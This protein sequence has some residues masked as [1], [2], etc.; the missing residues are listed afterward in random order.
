M[1][2]KRQSPDPVGP[3]PTATDLYGVDGVPEEHRVA[4]GRYTVIPKAK[5]L[6]NGNWIVEIVLEEPRAD[7]RRQYDFFGPMNEYSSAEEARRAGVEHA[8]GR[9]DEQ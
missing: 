4:H 6:H 3:D 9:L 8:I 7:G 2:F 1:L 5:L